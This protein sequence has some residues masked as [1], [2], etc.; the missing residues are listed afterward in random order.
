MSV[1][2]KC[3]DTGAQNIGKMMVDLRFADDIALL[4]G[5]AKSIQALISNVVDASR[6]TMMRLNSAETDI[7]CTGGTL[8]NNLRYR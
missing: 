2:L 3:L 1:A 8:S 5:E 7:L 6:K 4:S